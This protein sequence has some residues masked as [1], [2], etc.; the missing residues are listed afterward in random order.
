MKYTEG[1]KLMSLQKNLVWYFLITVQICGQ[2]AAPPLSSTLMKELAR[3]QEMGRE[4][5]RN[6]IEHTEAVVCTS[7][8]DRSF[9]DFSGEFYAP[10]GE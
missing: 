8:V 2:S 7:A 10:T 4:V 5:E 3:A 9:A 6:W 1:C